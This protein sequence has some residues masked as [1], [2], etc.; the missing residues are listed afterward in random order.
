[1]IVWGATIDAHIWIAFH[2]RTVSVVIFNLGQM[3]GGFIWFDNS[4]LV[5]TIHIDIF[6]IFTIILRFHIL[7]FFAWI[8]TFIFTSC[9]QF[10]NVSQCIRIF[11]N[12]ITGSS[13]T[14]Q[15]RHIGNIVV[16]DPVWLNFRLQLFQLFL[17]I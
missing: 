3:Y 7:L 12:R 17:F 8:F 2:H 6:L 1:M 14:A 5:K 16:I 11:K 9:T 15:N 10:L 13:F 4:R